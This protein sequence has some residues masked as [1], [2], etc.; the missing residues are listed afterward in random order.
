MLVI[1]VGSNRVVTREIGE[2]ADMLRHFTDD[3]SY[4][5]AENPVVL[6]AKP[7]TLAMAARDPRWAWGDPVG[8]LASRLAGYVAASRL[9]DEPPSLGDVVRAAAEYR[10]LGEIRP[11]GSISWSD[12]VP[13]QRVIATIRPGPLRG[14]T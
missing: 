5:H 12:F 8:P 9:D 10:G 2:Y 11:R 14:E 13:W 7:G 4:L 1:Y 3:F 6:A